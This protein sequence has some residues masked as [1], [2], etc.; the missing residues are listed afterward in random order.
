MHIIVHAHANEQAH[1]FTL[2]MKELNGFLNCLNLQCSTKRST[3]N[4]LAVYFH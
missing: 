1:T 3:P 2:L 4:F